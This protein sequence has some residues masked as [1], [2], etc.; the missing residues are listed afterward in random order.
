MT[1]WVDRAI[2]RMR[3]LKLSQS[4]LQDALGVTTRG[5][6]G[7]YLNRRR[8]P[9][10]AQLISLAKVLG[11]SMD[12][13]YIG[14]DTAPAGKIGEELADYNSLTTTDRQLINDLIKT[15]R[16]RQQR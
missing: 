1:D 5:A 6:I 7:H 4:D 13:L 15:M 11:M 3:Q 8:E 14:R 9:K 16:L 10:L 2:V 12:E